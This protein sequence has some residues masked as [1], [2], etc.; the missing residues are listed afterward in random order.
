MVQLIN[1]FQTNG[2]NATAVKEE[3]VSYNGNIVDVKRIPAKT[4]YAYGLR[5]MD[6]LFS[7]EE[8]ASSLLLESKSNKPPLDKD[9][10]NTMFDL[11]DKK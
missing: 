4:P 3:V 9:R 1:T 10:V 6:V 11:I 7:K 5:L 8:M 2:R